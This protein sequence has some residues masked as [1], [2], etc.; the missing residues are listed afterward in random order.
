MNSRIVISPTN[1]KAIKFVMEMQEK[2]HK[3]QKL[4]SQDKPLSAIKLK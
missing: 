3:L 4:M 2:K 1:K